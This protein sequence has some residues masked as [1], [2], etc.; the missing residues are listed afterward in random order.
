MRVG[1]RTRPSRPHRRWP[2]WSRRLRR[3]PGLKTGSFWP[4]QKRLWKAP[5]AERRRTTEASAE[6]TEGSGDSGEERGVERRARRGKPS[7]ERGERREE[8]EVRSA[9][10]G[11]RREERGG[12]GAESEERRA[13]SGERRAESEE[14]RQERREEKEERRAGSREQR[15]GSRPTC[16]LGASVPFAA[17][18]ARL[19][20]SYLR[21]RGRRAAAQP[22]TTGSMQSKF[23]VLCER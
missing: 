19:E 22:R 23:S 5:L 2:Q 1:F 3:R 18:S 14:Q 6:T 7:E 8:G 17:V 11:G 16:S 4:A 12:R 21:H 10:R 13:E 20:Y 9:E 15:A